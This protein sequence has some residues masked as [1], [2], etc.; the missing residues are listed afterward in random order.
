MSCTKLSWWLL[1]SWYQVGGAHC[2][3]HGSDGSCPIIVLFAMRTY[4]LY[5]QSKRLLICL[6][7]VMIGLLVP[8]GV[9]RLK[10]VITSSQYKADWNA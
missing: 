8:A 4:A 3:V 10:D 7:F 2:T 5:D 1:V 6:I 9:R